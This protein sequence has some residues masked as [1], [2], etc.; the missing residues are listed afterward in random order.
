M[1]ECVLHIKLVDKS[2]MG[3]DQRKHHAKG[4]LLDHWAEGLIVVNT[5]P[6]GE[7]MKDPMSLVLLQG[8]IRVELV[9][10]DPF[11][12]DDVGTNKTRDKI[13][14]VVGDQS[15]IFFMH[16]TTPG[17]VGE[18]GTDGGGHR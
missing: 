8:V 6:L 2:G 17:R 11:A 1:Q 5:G 4:G 3:D 13:P 18:G 9:L 7:A 15:I 14:S 10:K 16:G 12:G